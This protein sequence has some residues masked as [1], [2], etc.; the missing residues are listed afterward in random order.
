MATPCHARLRSRGGAA[1]GGGGGVPRASSISPSRLRRR[2][3]WMACESWKWMGSQP[4]R[5]DGASAVKG[6]TTSVALP[7]GGA[8]AA[9]ASTACRPCARAC[10]M[11]AGSADNGGAGLDSPADGDPV[12]DVRKDA[13]AAGGRAAQSASRTARACACSARHV[14]TRS[15]AACPPS[16]TA[17]HSAAP[18]TACRGP[19]AGEGGWRWCVLRWCVLQWCVLRWCVLR[20]CDDAAHGRTSGQ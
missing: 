20:W 11:R 12:A 7:G 4:H 5:L 2:A 18:T 16:A 6:G 17:P 8:A 3:S 13:R 19:P 10:A 9:A 15:S 1:A 14:A